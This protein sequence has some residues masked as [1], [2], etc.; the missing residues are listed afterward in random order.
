MKNFID[1]IMDYLFQ[2]L[3]ADIPSLL[4]RY[5]DL[6]PDALYKIARA[7]RKDPRLSTIGPIMDFYQAQ[8]LFPGG[9]VRD[10]IRILQIKNSM[11]TTEKNGGDVH[12]YLRKSEGKN[13]EIAF[14][15]S[16]LESIG[17]SPNSAALYIVS[18]DE[19]MAPIIGKGDQIIVDL[20]KTQIENGELYLIHK[21]EGFWIRRIFR[22]FNSIKL[23]TESKYL[24]PTLIEREEF[25]VIGKVVWIG[26]KR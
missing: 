2:H 25:S 18:N 1:T 17:I 4:K 21:D 19:A 12:E 8:I 26:H 20:T 5:P 22:E 14:S 11:A 9:N 15:F 16:I 24:P 13:S 10:F 23:V 7:D 6:K 3:K